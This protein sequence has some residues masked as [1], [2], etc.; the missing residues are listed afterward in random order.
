MEDE[1]RRTKRSVELL[2]G[3]LK[4]KDAVEQTLRNHVLMVESRDAKLQKTVEKLEQTVEHKQK[5]VDQLTAVALQMV[6]RRSSASAH[7]KLVRPL[8]AA[9]SDEVRRHAHIPPQGLCCLAS[10]ISAVA[11][12]EKLDAIKKAV[13]AN[14]VVKEPDGAPSAA[15]SAVLENRSSAAGA[16]DETETPETLV[17]AILEQCVQNVAAAATV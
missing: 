4:R 13:A 10:D 16:E 12:Q 6:E 1:L 15:A 14:L 7:V 11:V 3:D 2:R 9:Q 5:V 8:R 17:A